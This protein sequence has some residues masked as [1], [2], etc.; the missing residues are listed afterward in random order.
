MPIYDQSYKRWEGT[1]KSHAFRWW[2]IARG[3]IKVAFKKK[4]VKRVFVLALLPFVVFAVYV[5][6]LTHIGKVSKFVQGLAGGD[7]MPRFS[8]KVYEVEIEGDSRRFLEKL[9]AEG[10][11]L[12][13][14]DEPPGTSGALR[15][16]A[17]LRITVPE[18]E[19]SKKIRAIAKET[20]TTITGLVPPG[21]GAKFYNGY[22]TRLFL[23]Q[24]MLLLAVGMGLISKDVKF[25]A[26]PIYLAKPITAVEYVLG[27]L[28]TLLFFLLTV[29][30][31]PGILLFILQGILL[32]DFLYVRH[33]WWIPGAI[34]V[35]SL[36]ITLS[37]S[38][39]VLALSAFSRNARSAAFGG[40]A[41][42]W[43]SDMVAEILRNSTWND[44]YWLI[45]FMNNLKRVGEKIFRLGETTGVRWEWSL[46]IVLGLTVVSAMAL[47]RRVRAVEVVK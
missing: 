42:F 38:L 21:L 16:T 8:G 41:V 18:G 45:S 17:P 15:I 24:F 36:V 23:F 19:N 34:L 33:Y 40:A 26:L 22:L 28:G 9:R 4:V 29:T 37:G 1:F 5:Y 6:G 13:G 3:G 46:L 25:N 20:G 31:V 14:F 27:K 12:E 10:L 43:F 11:R 44:N 2:V 30:L 35:Y 7:A 39:I 47:V 32:G